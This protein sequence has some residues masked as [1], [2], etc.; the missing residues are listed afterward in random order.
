MLNVLNLVTEK[1]FT[2]WCKMSKWLCYDNSVEGS[3]CESCEF[4]KNDFSSVVEWVTV[5]R[6]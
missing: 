3:M 4:K 6:T 2:V 5:I 1:C